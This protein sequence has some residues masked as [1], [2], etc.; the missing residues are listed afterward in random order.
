MHYALM[1][2]AACTLTRDLLLLPHQLAIAAFL[3]ADFAAAAWFKSHL[4]TLLSQ[5]VEAAIPI[6]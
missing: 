4:Q 6:A 5:P 3:A 2:L 1:K